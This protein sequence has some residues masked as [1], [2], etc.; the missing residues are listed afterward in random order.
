MNLLILENNQK[1]EGAS[2]RVTL[3]SMKNALELHGFQLQ[4]VPADSGHS[5]LE[6]DMCYVGQTPPAYPQWDICSPHA[7]P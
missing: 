7:W 6:E 3:E 5:I 1:L 4:A 2:H